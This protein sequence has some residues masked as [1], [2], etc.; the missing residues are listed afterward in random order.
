MVIRSSSLLVKNLE[1]GASISC[2]GC[3]L[4]VR[5]VFNSLVS[6]DLVQETL[7]ITNLDKISVSE[8]VNLE[9]SL[10]FG[11]EVGGHLV[12]GHILTIGEICNKHKSLL[13]YELW[14][15]LKNSSVLKYLFY[16][17][18]ICIDGI[19]LTVGLIRENIF[20]IYLIPE[21]LSRTTIGEKKIGDSVNIEIDLYTKISVDSIERFL[22]KNICNQKFNNI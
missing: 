5:K 7:R 16:K 21:T 13:N 14:I 20:C 19:S 22:L 6:V 1:L 9:R 2:N 15:K 11:E 4:T 10:N 17:G 8:Y 12:S 18:F 3:C